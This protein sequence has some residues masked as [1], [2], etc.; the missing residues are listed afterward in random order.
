MILNPLAQNYQTNLARFFAP[1]DMV[2]LVGDARV[3]PSIGLKK[4][5]TND[6]TIRDLVLDRGD[7]IVVP[8][9]GFVRDPTGDST[10][11][12]IPTLHQHRSTLDLDPVGTWDGVSSTEFPLLA[13][14][15]LQS[16]HSSL[17]LTPSRWPLKK[18]SLVSLVNTRLGTPDQPTNALLALFDR[19]WDLNHGPSNWYLWRKSSVDPR[20]LEDPISGGGVGLGVDEGVGGGNEVYKVV[21]YDLHYAPNVVVSKKG[22]PWCTERFETMPS[23]CTYQMY[24]S[25]AEMWVLPDE[26]T[27]TLEVTERRPDGVKEDPAEKLKVR[28]FH[29]FPFLFDER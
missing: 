10:T 17:P 28:F 3:I 24:L 9:F 27:F 29:L 4:R 5:L 2:F 11:A 6:E 25:G 23:A 22:Q 14:A 26:W 1:T 15:H 12:P 16:L 20:L 21:D 13:A 7:A 18:A 8:S 19:R